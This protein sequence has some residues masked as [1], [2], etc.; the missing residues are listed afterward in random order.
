[1]ARMSR[2][3]VPGLGKIRVAELVPIVIT[4]HRFRTARQFWSYC[5]LGIVMRSSSDWVRSY[6]RWIRTEIAKTRGLDRNHNHTLKWI[7][8]GAA[9]T[10]LTRARQS[11]L[12]EHYDRMLEAGSR[13]NV[14]KLT[15]A[16]K[17]AAMTL[18]MWKSEEVHAPSGIGARK[19]SS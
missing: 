8:K 13:R 11:P 6:G 18:A 2:L 16:R 9:T 10:V 3:K 19:T 7:F 15:I 5:G 12:R 17:I 1:M 4:P 14:A